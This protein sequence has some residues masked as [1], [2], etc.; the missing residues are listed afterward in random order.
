MPHLDTKEEHCIRKWLG[1]RLALDEVAI[2][3]VRPDGYVGSIKEWSPSTEG[4]GYT[5]AQWLDEYYSS[6]LTIPDESW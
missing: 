1:Q 6:F 2:V 4:M 3:N 5:A